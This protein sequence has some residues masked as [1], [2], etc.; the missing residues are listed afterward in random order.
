MKKIFYLFMALIALA[1]CS[2]GTKK[3]Y[4]IVD[5]ELT[6]EGPLFD[7]PNTLQATHT[8]DLST[9]ENGLTA[10]NVKSVKLTKASIS[11]SDSSAT[12]FSSSPLPMQKCR[13]Q[14]FSIRSQK[15][16]RQ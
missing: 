1:S 16:L 14:E 6:A 7:G 15:T 5:M 10:E 9:I 3:H 12:S 8:I 4:A 13:K 11:T 2:E